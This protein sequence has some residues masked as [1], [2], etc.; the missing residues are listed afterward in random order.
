MAHHLVRVVLADILQIAI[1]RA[2]GRVGKGG[3]HVGQH[4]GPG[5]D[6]VGVQKAHHIA[7]GAGNALVQGIVDA[8]IRLAD[9]HGQPVPMRLQ[10]SHR[11]VGAG[12]VD[13]HMLAVRVRLHNHRGQAVGYGGGA[14]PGGGNDGNLHS[15]IV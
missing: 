6:V 14:V 4:L 1:D 2:H 9:Q 7:G 5:I 13:N 10:H 3:G 11:T 12:A 8:A 15:F